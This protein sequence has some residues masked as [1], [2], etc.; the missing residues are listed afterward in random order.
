MSSCLLSIEPMERAAPGGIGPVHVPFGHIVANEKWRGSELAQGM[1]GRWLA[2]CFHLF[3]F[4]FLTYLNLYSKT[5]SLPCL[6][7]KGKLSSF[8]RMT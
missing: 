4:I 7:F 2:P 1:Q 3:Y 8:L 6:C 5:H